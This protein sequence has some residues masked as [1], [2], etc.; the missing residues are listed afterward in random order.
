[1]CTIN[2]FCSTPEKSMDES[3]YLLIHEDRHLSCILKLVSFRASRP[4][5][6]AN[7]PFVCYNPLPPQPPNKSVWEFNCQV[8]SFN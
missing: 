7:T 6:E 3:M 8:V 1:M 4:A 2:M 5:S